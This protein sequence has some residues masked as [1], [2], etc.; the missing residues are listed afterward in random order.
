MDES[1]GKFELIALRTVLAVFLFLGAK[2]EV[3]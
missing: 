1:L 3:K 2:S